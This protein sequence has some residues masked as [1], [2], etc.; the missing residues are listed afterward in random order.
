MED[1]NILNNLAIKQFNESNAIA[2]DKRFIGVASNYDFKIL[3]NAYQDTVKIYADLKIAIQNNKC[4]EPGCVA[5]KK[6]LKQLDD[7]PTTSITFIEDLIG[8]LSV[9]ETPNY[10]VNNNYQY[11]VANSI[12]TAKPGF[13]KT[14]GYN[15]NLYLNVDGSQTIVFEG[16]MLEK[17]FVV[18]N[19]ALS[20]ILQAGSAFIAST[21]DINKGMLALL[22]KVGLFAAKDILKDG[23]LSPMAMIQD[24]FILKNQDG[25]FDYE[26]IDIGGGKGRNILK[27]DLDKIRKKADPF[28]NAEVSGLLSQE[29]EAVAAW[30]VY[31]AQGTSVEED[32]QMV[33]NAN[34]GSKAWSYEK[35]LP[36]S[37]DNKILF[38]SKYKEY[39]MNNYI[40]QF[41][42][43][44]FP[45]VKEDAAVFDLAEAKKAQAQKFIA[46]NN[47]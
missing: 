38:E 42:T 21:P 36:L 25:T 19:T 47:L 17:P 27:F 43:N 11:I 2:Y 4:S 7:A 34:A 18:N 6:M 8:E 31:I 15:L 35:D 14:D 33:Q 24:E 46:D 32:D 9:T 44:K 45:T 20:A 26:I 16:P 13:S 5:E 41:I 30:N 40:K 29:Q 22:T 10:D 1:K 37:Q 3:D 28:I 23:N 12:I 39:F